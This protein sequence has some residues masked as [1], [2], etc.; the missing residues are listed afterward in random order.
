MGRKSAD[1]SKET[2][3]AYSRSGYNLNSVD[4]QVV[5]V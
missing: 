1:C 2:G 5:Q 4:C 3:A